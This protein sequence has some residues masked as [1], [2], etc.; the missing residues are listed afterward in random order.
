MMNDESDH[1]RLSDQILY[2]SALQYAVKGEFTQ[3][4]IAAELWTPLSLQAVFKHT[5][6]CENVNN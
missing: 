6:I 3:K 4:T 5:V 1:F 2:S